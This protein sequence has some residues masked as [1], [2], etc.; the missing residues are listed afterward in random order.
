VSGI[1]VPWLEISLL[2][3]VAYIF[4]GEWLVWYSNVWLLL[5]GAGVVA[6]D[7]RLMVV[8]F[9][10]VFVAARVMSKAIRRLLGS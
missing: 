4:I 6:K 5:L 7:S 1:I 9:A 2:E 8:A 3:A 10:A